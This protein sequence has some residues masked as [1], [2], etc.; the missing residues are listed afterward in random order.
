MTRPPSMQ[1]SRGQ[2]ATAYA[3]N[4]L[5]TFEGGLGA[6]MALSSS[7][8]RSAELRP[9]TQ[10]LIGEQI[11]EYFEAWADRAMRGQNLRHPVPPALA[12]DNRVLSD[13][14][15][16]VRLGELAFQVPDV[17]G[18]VPFP[19]AFVCTRC[20]LHRECR[21]VDRLPQEAERF[22]QAC[23][24]GAE[25]CADDWQQ[26]DVV[27]THWSGDIEAISP[28][29]RYWAAQD[30]E[31]RE[32]ARCSACGLDR[33]YLRRPPGPLAGW[34]FECARC[35]TVRPILQRDL[36]TLELLGPLTDQ[37]QAL[38]AEINMEPVSYRASAAYYV[39]G[40]RLLVFDQD[41]YV[42]LL[43]G[44]R[45]GALEGFL[46][47]H[48]GYPA[49]Q[50]S[51]DQ[52]AQLLRAAGRGTDW[53]NYVSM[54]D[55]LAMLESGGTA[56]EAMIASTRSALARWEDD[57]SGTVFAGRQ[58]GSPGIVA[59]CRDRTR[60][61]R[62]F[63]PVR[64]A[65]E[66]ATLA[67][68]KLH[69]GQMSDGK[70]VSVDLTILDRFLLPDEL[71]ETETTQLRGQVRR[72]LNL[73]GVEEM[74]LI[75]DVRLCEYTFAYSRTSSAPVVQREKAG[76]AEMPVRLR[77]FDRVE[78]G[79]SSRHPVL[80][81]VQSNEGLYVRLDEETVLAWLEANAVPVPDAAPGVRLGGRLIEDF[82]DMENDPSAR[83]SR[84]LDEYRRERGVARHAFSF[85]YTLLHTMAHHLIGVSASMSGLDLGSFGEHIFAPD[86]AFLVYR[87][88]MTMDL[89]NLSSMW[90]DR[91]AP[92]FG[93]EVLD[94]M[95]DPTS[96]RCGSESICNHRGGA[97]PDCILIPES[98]CLTRNE[99]L[100]RSVLVGR[101]APRWDSGDAALTGYYE[102]AAARLAAA[103]RPGA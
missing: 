41:H 60:Y 12:V 1:R 78:V 43:A 62:R 80:C 13:G 69:G 98:A 19:L 42:S 92:D 57:W 94:R 23:P 2:L 18:Y 48:Y 82:A 29:Y 6:C 59:A 3:P 24:T 36:R 14:A 11:Q 74:R 101:G 56:P 34:H 8:N 79:D 21:R 54:R 91:G 85:V 46:T 61:V 37:N 39:H 5:F 77:L 4:S 55:L 73:L 95:I 65:V 58:Q 52:K 26:I 31:V 84:F 40:D 35:R 22:R 51:D 71:S 88:G 33:F 20:D 83:F 86:L 30:E 44:G 17:V 72:R 25:G 68:E 66:H 38:F 102:I 75:R 103:G 10:H 81:L 7:G 32:I 93:N 16:H 47:T 99:L 76:D 97:C 96:L 64:M 49:T 28:A 27:L 53:D 67:Q 15:V 90:R 87:R 50:M 100:S 9:I 45:T 70:D 89:G 63:D